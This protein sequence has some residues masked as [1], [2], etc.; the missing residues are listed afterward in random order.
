[1]CALLLIKYISDASR[2]SDRSIAPV[3]SGIFDHR[4]L[5]L[6]RKFALIR[7]FWS[8]SPYSEA[9]TILTEFIHPG[10]V[11]AHRTYRA[12]IKSGAQQPIVLDCNNSAGGIFSARHVYLLT[13]SLRPASTAERLAVRAH[14]PP[15]RSYCSPR[16]GTTVTALGMDM[17]RQTCSLTFCARS[18][19]SEHSQVLLSQDIEYRC[20]LDTPL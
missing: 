9:D 3:R 10:N 18:C 16:K 4:L 12:V 15:A 7:L 19:A 11:L 17:F 20:T 8:L 1:M 6:P 5:L 2:V 13:P 14:S